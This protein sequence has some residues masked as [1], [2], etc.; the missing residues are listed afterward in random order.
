MTNVILS[1][2]PWNRTLATSLEQKTGAAWL[3]I[4]RREDFTAERLRTV[5]V[6]RIFVPHWSYIIPESIFESYETIVFHMTDLPF[7]RG[8]SPLQNLIVRGFKTTKI[9]ALRVV[10]EL[11][12]GDIYLKREL[13]LSGS[14]HQIFERANAIIEEMILEIVTGNLKPAPQTGEP[15][16]FKRRRPEESEVC[17]LR[18]LQQMYDYIRMLDAEGYPHAF[19]T[20]EHFKFEFTEATYND[21]DSVTARVRITKK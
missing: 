5:A 7:G 4:D 16:F 14:A 21:D 19:L 12:A 18:E 3:L 17:H 10:R 13:D 11:D 15:T 9:S 20:T 8:G 1:E 2:K 6:E